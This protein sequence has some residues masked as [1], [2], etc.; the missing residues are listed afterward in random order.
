M[1][2]RQAE[3]SAILAGPLS[4]LHN[5]GVTMAQ[6]IC[7]TCSSTFHP[8]GRRRYC[9]DACRQAAWR[10]R[11]P[12]PPPPLPLGG[13]RPA[14]PLTVYECPSCGARYL[15]EQRCPDCQLFCR[16]VGPGGRCPHCE[17][18]VA[19]GDLIAEGEG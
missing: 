12:I 18:P 11:H 6:S 7:P 9:S 14:R 4:P 15:G 2:D 13:A 8:V 19:L 3:D 16:R 1:T 17:E 10:R 5:D